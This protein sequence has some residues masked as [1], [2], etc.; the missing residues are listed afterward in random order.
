LRAAVLGAN[1]GI[2]SV[3][4]IVIGVAGATSVRHALV[5]AGL[6]GLSAG[7]MSMAV[8]EYVSVSAQRD[9][10]KAMLAME[11]AE[12][13]AMPEAEL[14]ELE[15][16]LGEAGMSE[17]TSK[18]AARELTEHD[19]LGTHARVEL[20]INPSQDRANPVSA[21]LAS[22]GAFIAGGVIPFLAVLF[23]PNTAAV[24]VTVIAVVVALAITGFTSARLGRAPASMAVMRNVAGGLFAMGVTYLIG[25]LFGTTIS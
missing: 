1:D 5:V 19:A 21:A 20:D 7:A 10:E 13:A 15:G 18:V 23:A 14:T 11:K 17:Q 2:V 9:S 6:A 12:L 3:A 22:L 8:G 24:M 16:L 25:T 4:G